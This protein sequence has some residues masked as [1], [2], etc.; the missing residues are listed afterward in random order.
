[1]ADTEPKAFSGIGWNLGKGREGRNTAA[2][3]GRKNKRWMHGW[4]MDVWLRQGAELIDLIDYFDG[5]MEGLMKKNLAI[6]ACC[7]V[8]R[9][10]YYYIHPAGIAYCCYTPTFAVLSPPPPFSSLSHFSSLNILFCVQRID[11]LRQQH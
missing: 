9:N 2:V 11:L 3:G 7:F 1:M 4:R 8:S 6:T 5:W 10:P